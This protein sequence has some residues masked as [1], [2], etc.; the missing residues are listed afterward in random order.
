MADGGAS[1]FIFLTTALLVSG[2]VSVVLI[3]QW[4]DMAQITAQE[5]AALEVQEATSVDFAGDPMMVSLNTTLNEIT[6]YVQNTGT[7]LLDSSTLVVLVDGQ[8]VTSTIN[9]TVDTFTNVSV[10]AEVIGSNATNVGFRNAKFSNGST[11]TFYQNTAAFIIGVESNTYANV[12][13]VGTG[14]GSTF[15]IGGLENEES[16]TIYTDFVG[17][18][19]TANVAF[20][21]CVIDGQSSN[22]VGGNSGIGFVD[23]IFVRTKGGGYANGEVVTFSSGGAGGGAPTTNATGTIT[24]N[25]T[26]QGNII[27]CLLYTSDAADE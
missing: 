9:A 21:D 7:T 22:S 26:G 10:H 13:T 14:N 23:T 17:D 16:I 25:D 11:G 18:N 4:G 3:N 12:V 1:S 5:T 8:T 2:L 15:K 24:T 27:S 19:N 6:F 20:L